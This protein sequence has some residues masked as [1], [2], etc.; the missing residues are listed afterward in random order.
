MMNNNVYILER[1]ENV[2]ICIY[3]VGV[4]WISLIRSEKGYKFCFINF[5]KMSLDCYEWLYTA[6]KILT[7]IIKQQL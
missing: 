1:S 6:I 2:C 3:Q 5:V 4:G 7:T